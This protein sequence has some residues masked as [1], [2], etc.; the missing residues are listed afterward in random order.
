[1]QDIRFQS[2]LIAVLALGLGAVS[3]FSI[4]SQTA[5]GYPAG[6]AVSYGANPAWSVGGVITNDGEALIIEAPAD[7]AIVF[8]DI[9][10]SLSSI[11]STCSTVVEAGLGDSASSDIS[12]ATLGRFTV[13][14]NRE[15]YGYTRYHPIHTVNLTTGGQINP[16]DQLKL[17]TDVKWDGYCYDNVR[18]SYMIAG[19]YAQP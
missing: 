19:Y 15:S 8:T 17:Y 18:L 4:S 5:Q 16:G 7:Q 1:M 3:A 14:A 12:S 2:S 6:A 10:L 9:S 11:H 13:G